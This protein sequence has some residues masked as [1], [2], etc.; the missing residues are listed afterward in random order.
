M[1]KRWRNHIV[2]SNNPNDLAYNYPLY[3]AIRKYG[4]DNFSFE[5]V[6]DCS[7]DQ[8]D[9]REIYWINYYDALN[10]E[11]GYNQHSGGY[12]PHAVK[13]T[14]QLAEEIKELLANTSISQYELAR[15]YNV[16]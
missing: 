8:L 1:P 14:A 5:V 4:L 12:L 9:E 3:K 6:E 2:T 10:K 7:I 11:K 13:L 15:L 16:D